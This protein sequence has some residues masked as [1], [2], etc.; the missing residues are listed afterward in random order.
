MPTPPSPNRGGRPRPPAPGDPGAAPHTSRFARPRA[1]RFAR[2][3]LAALLAI[4]SG[5]GCAGP[6]ADLHLAPLYSRTT[7]ADDVTEHEGLGGF[8]RARRDPAAGDLES[9]ELRPLFGWRRGFTDPG[10][11]PEPHRDWRPARRGDARVDFLPPFGFWRRDEDR[12]RSLLAPLWFYSSGPAEGGAGRERDLLALPGIIWRTD[13][14]R[15][16][17]RAWFPFWG[18][19]ERFITFDRVRFALFPLYASAERAD[20]THH[21]LLFPVVGWTTNHPAPGSTA[22]PRRQ[23]RLWPLFGTH[24]KPGHWSKQFFLWP[25]F[26]RRAEGLW[27]EEQDQLHAWMAWPLV[28]WTRRSSYRSVSVLWPFFGFAWDPRGAQ[29]D[30]D[31]DPSPGPDPEDGPAEQLATPA[32]NPGGAYWAWDGPWPL[33]RIQR[34]GRS[35]LAEERTRL[36]PFYSHFRA[37]GL[38]W[39]TALWPIFQRRQELGPDYERASFH[40]IPFYQSFELTRSRPDAPTG[41]PTGFERPQRERWNRLWPIAVSEERDEWRRDAFPT[42]SPLTRWDLF[43]HYWGWLVELWAV[44]RDRTRVSGRS[45]LGLF[46]HESNGH[47]R[48]LSLSGLWSRR[49]IGAGPEAVSETSLLFGLLRWRSGGD[50]PGPLAPAFPGPGWPGEWAEPRHDD[51]WAPYLSEPDR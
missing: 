49:T 25:I 33:V 8:I 35:P 31:R 28:G 15:T 39:R 16:T 23:L 50:D 13:G 30:P 17:Q 6:R 4:V 18:D 46:R 42:L 37:D 3:V 29:P 48:R 43:E 2:P 32:A 40:V 26:T 41:L 11:L 45:F 36:W 20:F 47:E 21:H 10:D 7:G 5:P 1:S 51:P 14:T 27:R 44:E 24:T 22:P 12:V 9:F 38:W 34:G 19:L